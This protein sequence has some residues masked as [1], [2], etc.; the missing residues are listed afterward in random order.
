M[1]FTLLFTGRDYLY[2]KSV[3]LSATGAYFLFLFVYPQTGLGKDSAIVPW[4]ALFGHVVSNGLLTGYILN[5]I[6]SFN[7]QPKTEN[8]SDNIKKLRKFY[9]SPAPAKKQKHKVRKVRLVKPKKL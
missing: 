5:K 9:L 1:S 4:V 2:S 7:K 8:V 3:A 6:C